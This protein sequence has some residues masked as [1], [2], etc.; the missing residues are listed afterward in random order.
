MSRDDA[1]EITDRLNE[2]VESICS[3]F[4][5]GWKPVKEKGQD[6]GLMTPQ[7]KVATSKTAKTRKLTSSFK[8][9]L[10]GSHKGRWFRFSQSV[11]GYGLAL[12]YYGHT[13]RIP[14]SKDDFREAFQFAREHLGMAEERTESPEDKAAREERRSKEQ[15]ERDARN[16]KGAAEAERKRQA[17]VLNVQEIWAESKPLAGS[18]GEQYL[19]GRGIPPISEWPWQPD[20]AIRFHP[21]LDFEPDRDVGNYPAIVCKVVDAFNSHVALWI[22][23]LKRDKPEKADLSPSPKIGRGTTAG[24]AIRL[25]GDAAHIDGAEGMETALGAWFLDGCRRPVWSF[26]STSGMKNFEPPMFVER[27]NIFKDGD[28]AVLGP[29]GRVLPPPGQHAAEELQKRMKAVGIKCA[30][31]DVCRDGDA[32]DLWNARQRFEKSNRKDEKNGEATNTAP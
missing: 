14:N 7:I 9:E 30:V 23:Y 18:M 4:W 8:V 26:M 10:S 29:Q 28:K 6:I 32:L 12:L 19:I 27:L 21:A 16:K 2:D 22:V 3:K 31:N 15:A 13:D 24:G 25:G 17:K 20:E 11:G 5:P 1:R